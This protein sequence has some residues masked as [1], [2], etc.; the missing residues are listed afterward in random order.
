MTRDI[1]IGDLHGCWAEFEQL[2][3]ELHV[4]DADR[5]ISVGDLVDRGPD[6]LRLW[7]YFRDRP[8]SV[9]V[10]GNHERKHVRGVLSPSQE[11][12]RLQ[13]GDEYETFRAWA[14]ELP[15]VFETEHCVIVHGGFDPNL[16][17]DQQRED[18][19][20]ATTGGTKHLART[21]GDRDWADLYRGSKP[22]VFGHRVVGDDVQRWGE[23]AWG[24]DTGACHGGYLTALVV[25]DFTVHRVRAHADHW[26]IERR[27]W[28][29][30]LLEAQSW[31]SFRFKKLARELGV[32]EKRRSTVS[33]D[34]AASLR[35][36]LRALD[37]ALPA[38]I[39][40]ATARCRELEAQHDG[41]AFKHAAATEPYPGLL[42]SAHAGSLDPATAKTQLNTPEAI[43]RALKAF[44]LPVPERY[45]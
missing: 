26:S 29:R 20:S 8:N 39:D 44:G 19:L 34:F 5:L 33:R 21:L 18:V 7:R 6:S 25:P 22:I 38:L 27:T 4:T 40:R 10:M 1:I 17:L 43:E 14:A 2:L 42:F 32:L 36:W 41:K 15:Y 3:D 31:A 13:F 28:E 37:A 11:I 12:V 24:I 23:H 9:V 16:P 45:G 35:A 30:P